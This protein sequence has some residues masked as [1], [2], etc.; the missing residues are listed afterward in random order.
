MSPIEQL[1]GEYPSNFVKED[2]S[3]NSNFVFTPD[4]DYEPRNLFDSE[5][6]SVSV[7]SFVECEHYVSG[8][9]DFQ[10]VKSQELIYQTSLTY[11]VIFLIVSS[12]LINNFKKL[13]NEI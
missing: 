6:N 8:G 4:K 12:F 1:C 10:P 11:L 7:N 2:I 9:W 13:K 5:G 3:S